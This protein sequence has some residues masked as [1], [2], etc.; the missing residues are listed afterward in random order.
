MYQNQAS[1]HFPNGFLWGGATAANQVEGGWDEGGKGMTI[2]DCLPY[3]EVGV[4]DFTKQFAYSS[5]DLA[6]ALAA[7][8]EANYPKRRAIDFYH[9][10]KEDIALFAEM[11]FKV[12]RVSICWSRIYTDPRDPEPNEEGIA[13]YEDMFRECR[14]HGIEPLVTLSHYDP[15]L[16][17]VTDYQGWYSREVIG[18][19][20]KYARTCFERFGHLVKYWL[21]FNEVDAML[22]HAVTS[23]GLIEDR[24]PGKNFDEVI[25]QAMHHQMVAS[26]QA[27]KLCHE[28]V[29]GLQVGC[30][31]TK[32]CFY[33]YSCKPEDNLATQQRMRGV[34]R[35]VDIQVF[36]EYPRYLWKEMEQKGVSIEYRPEDME[37]LREGT[38]DF[39][40]FSY[41]MTSC[42]AAD[43][44]GLDMAPGNTVNGVKNPYLPSSE[45][46]WQTDASGLRYS[47]VE[48]YDRYRK[49]LF[50]V[51]NGLGARDTLEEDGSVHDPYRAAYLEEHVRAMSDAINLDGV[52]LIGYT[53]WGCIDL[54]S[55]ST[56]QMSK[57]YGFIYVDMDDYGNGTQKRYKKDSFDYY[58]QVIESNG[59]NLDR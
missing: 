20:V 51:E 38:V 6:E 34:Y 58:K 24:F 9:H 37:L 50:I 46:G 18:L 42:M 1:L 22:R 16:A 23:G 59:T 3:R 47:L 33:P 2:Q 41:Y 10:Y 12:L 35:Y 31:M 5:A 7:G 25:Y 40:S 29:P 13:F 21:T 53:W 19:F 4:A 28:M 49:P 43:T 26:A 15:P 32:L 27:V 57:R 17:L 39:V 30:M 14:K 8:P 48:L 52:D 54:V 56:R 11:G 45:W 55:E 44:E 36:G